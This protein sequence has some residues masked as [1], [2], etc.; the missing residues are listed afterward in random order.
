M[1]AISDSLTSYHD[2]QLPHLPRLIG[3]CQIAIKAPK[4]LC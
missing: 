1:R 4:L 2:L 3:K